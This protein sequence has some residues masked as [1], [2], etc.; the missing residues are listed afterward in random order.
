MSR[1]SRGIIGFDP[2]EPQ[3][4]MTSS[5]TDSFLRI[6][7]VF[8]PNFEANED[9][10]PSVDLRK[11]LDKFVEGVRGIRSLAD[12]ILVADLKNPR[13]LKVSTVQSAS[14]LK[15]RLGVEAIPVVTARDSNRSAT[16][17]SILTAYALGIRKVMLVWGDRYPAGSPVVNAYNFRN[18]SEL[19]GEARRLAERAGVRCELYAP[20]D[21]G[22]LAGAR[23][24]AQARSRLGAGASFLLAQP[25]TSD[26]GVTLRAHLELLR[27]RGLA[28][29]VLPCA[30]PFRDQNDV[31][32]CMEDFGW[33]L[34]DSLRTLA[35]SGEAALLTEARN[36][37]REAR[38]QGFPGVY[39][40]TRG[41][42]EVASAI[43]G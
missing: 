37:A 39:V 32:A 16:L 7:E 2:R 31:R 9:S 24:F 21:L 30:F 8:P 34:P 40:S 42:P 13:R 1:D 29:K 19:I 4:P 36:V 20:V 15:E 38:A 26:A 14:L 33:A 27:S 18:L 6:V 22:T 3:T 25:P 23:G 11:S 10:N 35:A 43:L 5:R 12:G 17:T 28:H 41:R